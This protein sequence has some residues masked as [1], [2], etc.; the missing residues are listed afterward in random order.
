MGSIQ[1]S[2]F[3]IDHLLIVQSHGAKQG[4]KEKKIKI[5]Q[6]FQQKYKYPPRI[7]HNQELLM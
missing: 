7:I 2:S 3:R 6:E 4:N 1:K 5:F